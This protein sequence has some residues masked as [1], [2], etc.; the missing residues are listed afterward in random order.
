METG[1][2]EYWK[3][4]PIKDSRTVARLKFIKKDW[5]EIYQTHADDMKAQ[6]KNWIVCQYDDETWGRIELMLERQ[7]KLNEKYKD[8]CLREHAE[9][10]KLEASQL[11]QEE[12][13]ALRENDF[14][15]CTQV[16][17][18][19]MDCKVKMEELREDVAAIDSQMHKFRIIEKSLR[20]QVKPRRTVADVSRLQVP[21]GNDKVL[22]KAISD[23]PD[24]LILES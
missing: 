8:D 18:D 13:T 7:R 11:D 23:D 21:K 2:T 15:L 19:K 4:N 22:V 24:L 17:Y 10:Y 14:E 1:I 6:L 9:H 20:P 3:R 5:K 12:I 16:R